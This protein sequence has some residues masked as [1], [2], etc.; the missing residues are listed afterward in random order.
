MRTDLDIAL[1]K[2]EEMPPQS[3][4]EVVRGC[5]IRRKANG[6]TIMT[7]HYSAIPER[8]PE[9]EAGAK[10][11]KSERA[12]YSSQSAWNKEQEIDPHA[13]GGEAVFGPILSNPDLYKAVVISD[14]FWQPNP[15]WEV[16]FGFD[17]GKTNATALLKAYITREEIDPA[18]GSK[19]PFDIYLAGEYY[20]MKRGPSMQEPNG[21]MNNVDENVMEMLKMPDIDRKRY[22]VADPAIFPDTQA[23]SK[24]DYTNIHQEY[25]KAGFH[26]MRPYEGTRSD[27][28][29]V[30]WILSDLWGG[31]SRGRRPRLFIVCRNPSDKPQPGLHPYDCPNLLWE[32]KRAKRV[33]MSARQLTK[34]NPSDALVDK[35]NHLRDA[36]KYLTGTIKFASRK[37]LHEEMQEKLEGLDPTSRNI[38]ARH[39]FSEAVHKGQIDWNGRPKKKAAPVISMRGRWR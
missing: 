3:R 16:A 7:L 37:P 6:H 38:Y 36:M 12:L 30:E 21:W 4:V 28:T 2:L 22:I 10:W 34:R 13:M 23:Q 33:E 26:T 25:K 18:T 32:L 11:K 15:T 24:G 27:I 19:R 35:Q 29:F 31:L 5:A 17:H 14:P 9:T 1:E 20:S 39:L 8:D